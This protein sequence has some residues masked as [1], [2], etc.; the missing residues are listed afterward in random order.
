MLL[1]RVVNTKIFLIV[2]T[3]LASTHDFPRAGTPWP[4][5]NL[6]TPG[7]WCNGVMGLRG[8][9]AP[10]LEGVKPIPLIQGNEALYLDKK[11]HKKSSSVI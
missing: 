2:L 1:K 6:G 9:I 10:R 7:P 8:T 4:S 3:N 5:K 11:H